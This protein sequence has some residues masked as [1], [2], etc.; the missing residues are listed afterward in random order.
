[1][2]AN[3]LSQIVRHIVTDATLMV[4]LPVLSAQDFTT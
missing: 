4:W 1:M 2:K 3:L